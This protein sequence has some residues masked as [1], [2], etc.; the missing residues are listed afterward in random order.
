MDEPLIRCQRCT[1]PGATV[2]HGW[3]LLCPG[4]QRNDNAEYHED[5][6]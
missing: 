2:A 5:N 3:A 1:R 4:C 6:R